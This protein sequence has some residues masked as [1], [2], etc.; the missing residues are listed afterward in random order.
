VRKKKKQTGPPPIYHIEPFVKP[1]NAE[2]YSHAFL[3][4]KT[5]E[6]EL[7]IALSPAGYPRVVNNLK[8]KECLD[9]SVANLQQME[10]CL[11][12]TKAKELQNYIKDIEQFSALLDNE[13]LSDSA[14]S[15]MRTDIE[16]HKMSV[17]IRFSPSAVKNSLA[18]DGAS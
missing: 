13:G 7:L 8:V 5:W 1:P 2:I 15:R 6:G 4:W 14:L 11:N 17:E 18:P 3:F 12:Q 10:S 16:D 9:Q